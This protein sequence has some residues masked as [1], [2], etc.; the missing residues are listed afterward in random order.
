VSDNDQDGVGDNADRDDD[1]DFI[2][3]GIDDFPFD[4]ALNDGSGLRDLTELAVEAELKSITGKVVDGYV[5][6]A[7]VYLDLDFDSEHD[8]NEPSAVTDDSGIFQ[9]KLN[10][11]AAQCESLAPVVVD[12]P[13]GA[14]DSEQGEV[15]EAYQMVAP[16][17]FASEYLDANNLTLS[18]LTSV[19]WSEIKV[20]LN[21]DAEI[22]YSC[23]QLIDEVSRRDSIASSITTAITNIVRHYNITEAQIYADFIEGGDDFAKQQAL[24][25]VKALKKSFADTAAL[26]ASRPDADWA[27]VTYYKF[28]SID[29]DDLYPDAWY[30]DT[31]YKQGQLAVTELMKMSSDLQVE[32]RLIYFGE[33]EFSESGDLKFQRER[34]Y[35]SRGG[36][37]SPYSCN[38]KEEVSYT[39]SGVEYQMQNLAS[40]V[41]VMNSDECVFSSFA[42][43]IQG[44]YLFIRI[45]HN[46]GSETGAQFS[47]DIA[48]NGFTGLVDWVDFLDRP[49]EFSPAELQG[50]VSQLPYQFCSNDLAGAQHVNRARSLALPDYNLTVDRA[51]DGS[52]QVRTDY[53][54]GRSETVSYGPQDLLCDEYDIDLDSDGIAN[55][56]DDDID[57]DGV[58]NADDLFPADPLEWADSDGDGVGDNGDAF[59]NNSVEYLD[60]DGDGIG[61]VE[62][63]DDD[64]DG[65]SDINDAFPLDGRYATDTDNDGIADAVDDDSDNDGVEDALDA[66]PLDAFNSVDFDGDGIGD[67]TDTDDD[68]DGV[69]DAEDAFPRDATESSDT[70][71]DGV[72]DNSDAFPDDSAEFADS[73]GDGVG[74]N[75]DAYPFDPNY[76]LAWADRNYLADSITRAQAATI[77]I[78]SSTGVLIAPNYAITAAHSP[79]DGNNEITPNLI[80]E[81]AWGEKRAIVNVFY[82]VERDFAIVELESPYEKFGTVPIATDRSPTGSEA[83]IVGNPSY[84]VSAGLSRAV[85]FGTVTNQIEPDGYE[86]FSDFHAFGGYSGS[87]VYNDK[88]DLVGILSMAGCCDYSPFY[89]NQL[90][91]YNTT[92]DQYRQENIYAIPLEYINDFLAVYEVVP[93]LV[94]APALP[95]NKVDRQKQPL[96][97]A[98][99]LSRLDPIMDKAR[100][101]TVALWSRPLTAVGEYTKNPNCSGALVA[102][103]LV[104]TAA[105]CVEGSVEVTVG[106]T[107]RELRSARVLE[108]SP[109]G[110][111]AMLE[112][113]QEAPSGYPI[114]E[115]ATEPMQFGDIGL[116]VGHPRDQYYEFGGW[117]VTT[118]KAFSSDKGW[119]SVWGHSAGGS[120]GG[121]LINESGQIVG[122]L[123]ASS[124]GGDFPIGRYDN[125]YLYDIQDP[126]LQ[127]TS[128][129]PAPFTISFSSFAGNI[130]EHAGLAYDYLNKAGLSRIVNSVSTDNAIFELREVHGDNTRVG[131]V[132]QRDINSGELVIEFGEE[133][134]LT[135]GAVDGYNLV[136]RELVSTPEGNV[137]ILAD[138]SYEST[139]TLA[140]FEIDPSGAIVRSMQWQGDYLKAKGLAIEG[141]SVYLVGEVMG[142]L[143]R[144]YV[145]NRCTF[146]DSGF[147]CN[148]SRTYDLRGQEY[149]AGLVVTQTHLVVGGFIDR[150]DASTPDLAAF[151]LNKETLEPDLGIGEG[152]LVLVQRGRSE[153][154]SERALGVYG[155]LDGGVMLV[156][157]EWV[158]FV[159][160]NFAVKLTSQGEI[161]LGFG[162]GGEFRTY[163]TRVHLKGLGQLNGFIETDEYYVFSGSQNFAGYLGWALIDGDPVHAKNV[164]SRDNDLTLVISN[165]D[166]S[167]ADVANPL[168]YFDGHANEYPLESKLIDG[169]IQLLYRSEFGDSVS[170]FVTAPIQDKALNYLSE[171]ISNSPVRFHNEGVARG[172]NRA[173]I[174]CG[175]VDQAG[176]TMSIEF[177]YS[178]FSDKDDFGHVI[179]EY[180]VINGSRFNR[181]PFIYGQRDALDIGSYQYFMSY[182]DGRGN[183]EQ[184][185]TLPFDYHPDNCRF[186]P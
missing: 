93:E 98:E 63:D 54:D 136:P 129:W 64:A 7:F 86:R 135:L 152:G 134:V 75:E 41:G 55:S 62:D 95:K 2:P 37:D 121:P 82:N 89:D 10:N 42:E 24:E 36:D 25:I 29:G 174:T 109:M 26:R 178:S 38:D 114:L 69:A 170:R 43:S 142:S 103:Q 167:L 85:S 92:W 102:P 9:L 173:E 119:L 30:R 185:E 125:D 28:S 116:M 47:Y 1:N 17:L 78:T 148:A 81:N 70:D 13:V 126:H 149:A 132:A 56:Q 61:N 35:E 99:E 94:V 16:P 45:F 67:F 161:D 52:Y 127:D 88:G 18:P 68:N 137:L 84:V 181:G 158:P 156:G 183:V 87:G 15:L 171:D 117:I 96:L 131:K 33:R 48:Q 138:S 122:V 21:L 97:N 144:D 23:T 146:S 169:Q 147:D 110:D 154:D 8:A 180:W 163:D 184:I 76:V 60:T 124:A 165:K 155:T 46:D 20:A 104:F 160:S 50:F 6:G 3:D 44:R 182:Q 31:N 145:L 65:V 123:T 58:L 51:N 80:A 157:S 19:L 159:S 66:F 113:D 106:F 100:Q 111:V 79:L 105:H 128:P 107:G 11:A 130:E 22:T 143:T 53:P 27:S 164:L 172:S 133:G 91:V 112:L 101:A 186:R 71:G 153:D 83:F 39:N 59:P 162:E 140:L 151:Y 118:I 176:T 57:G 175:R 5:S 34:E 120:S 73:D 74:D 72:G 12:V 90:P 115:V 177:S 40:Q 141:D 14:F 166:G 168:V 32:E 150:H 4:S 139:S 108:L 77:R 49:S 179:E